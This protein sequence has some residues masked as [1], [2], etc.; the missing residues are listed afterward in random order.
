MMEHNKLTQ[1]AAA[2]S[3]VVL[4]EKNQPPRIKKHKKSLNE[5]LFIIIMLA[6]P[7][8]HFLVFFV[9]INIDTVV[10]TFQQKTL[11]GKYV[12]LSEPFRNYQEFFSTAFTSYSVFPKAI[13]NSI[14]FFLLNNV[15]IVPISVILTYFL[16]KKMP[17]ANVF[18]IIFYLPSIISVVV[19]TMLYRFMFDSSIGL[20]DSILKAMGLEN[21]IPQ[22]GWLGSKESALG[23]VIFYCIWSG[24]G[25]NIVLLT[26]AM[27]RVPVEIIESGKLDGVGMFRELWSIVIPLIGTTLATLFMLGT[28]VIFTFFLQPKLL[29]NGNPNGETFTIAMYIVDNVKG[30]I[31]DL[32]M[33]ATVG[34]ICAIVG[35]PLVILTRK[36]LDKAFPVYEY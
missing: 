33:G 11:D 1:T 13:R 31:G 21:L 16:Y 7:V 8:L 25:G 34:V 2:E 35:T 12:F 28:T 5:K 27:K 17:L 23:L 6:I 9:Y 19:L 14:I 4:T 32:T 29:T 20:F 22:H 26:G 3:S 24:L 30:D 10:L 18:R 36:L 15:V